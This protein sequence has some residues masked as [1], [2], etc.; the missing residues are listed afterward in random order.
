MQRLLR[1]APRLG[2]LLLVASLACAR[3]PEAPPPTAVPTAA[4]AKPTAAAP[5]ATT[6]PV[7]APTTAASAAAKPA[8]QTAASPVAAAR[9]GELVV[10]K[11]QEAPGLDPAKNPASAALRIFDLT[12]S[13]LTRLD[14]QMRPTP[15]LATSWDQPDAKTYVFHLRQGVKFHNGRPLT[16]EDVKYTYERIINPDTASIAKSFFDVIDKI[17]TPDPQTVKI[18]L[19]EPYAPFLVNTAS[20]WAGIVAKEIVDANNGDLNKVEAGSGPFKL[21][22]W[23]PQTR[24]VLV[25]NPDYYIPNEPALDKITFQIMPEESARIAA[26]RTGNIQFTILTAAGADTLQNDKSVT[27]VT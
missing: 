9:G 24:A 15:D 12:Y 25:R 8:G 3:A 4:P 18:T 21:Q 17:E 5:A 7:A 10:G 22:E 14:D 23:T 26:L 13:R 2:A 20:T 27:V 16:S 6:A 11:D 19:K 1:L